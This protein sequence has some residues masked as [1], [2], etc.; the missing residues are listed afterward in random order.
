MSSRRSVIKEIL[1]HRVSAI[2]RTN[3]QRL[4]AEAMQA[5]VEGGFRLG[6]FTMT[7]PGALELIVEFAKKP[8]LLVGAG[9]VLTVEQAR[10]AVNAGPVLRYGWARGQ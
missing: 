6:E 9:T 1:E 10:A 5:A 7:T 8:D 4:A 2:V 3:E